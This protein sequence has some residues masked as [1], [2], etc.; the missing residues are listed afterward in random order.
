MIG[1]KRP[2][3]R[4][5]P[6]PS[7]EEPPDF[8][9][10]GLNYY[11]LFW[12]FFIC[13][14]LGAVVE[15]VFMLL[16]KGEVQNRSSLIY[17]QFS[18]VWGMGGVLF[19]VCLHRLT[20]RRDLAVFLGGTVLGGAYEYLCS[21]LQEAVFGASFWDYSHIPF[22]I[23]GRVNL[24]YAMFWG[25]A[26]VIWV[27][28]LYPRMC[29]LIRRIPNRVGIPLTWALTVFM[30]LNMLISA[31]ALGRWQ[32]RQLGQPAENGAERFLD[33]HFPDERM[34]QNYSTLTYVGE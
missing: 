27:K 5:A 29:A 30:V 7:G 28:D 21:W 4:R 32:Q 10:R 33:L 14:L 24:L 19:T 9:A 20:G 1:L 16:T 2:D 17:G 34:Y 25:V 13:S 31:A 6:R 3:R 26:A 8:F 15:T 23:N 11:K 22:N 18:V 12:I